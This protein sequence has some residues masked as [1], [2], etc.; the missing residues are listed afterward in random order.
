MMRWFY[1]IFAVLLTGGG[2]ANLLSGIFIR[3]RQHRLFS[4]VVGAINCI[5]I[6]IGTVLGIFTIVVLS[7]DSVQEIYPN[8][9]AETSDN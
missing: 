5:Q 4:I 9:T 8:N 7:R 3:R 6:P 1:A 2:L